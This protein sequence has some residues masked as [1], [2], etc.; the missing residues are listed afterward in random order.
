VRAHERGHDR[1]R[2]LQL[3][4][5]EMLVPNRHEAA[6]WYKRVLGLE[7]VPEYEFWAQDP[8]GP[9]MVSSDCG[10][11]KLALFRG[12]TDSA[13]GGPGFRLV[14]FR[15]DGGGFI[16]FVRRLESLQLRDHRGHAVTIDSVVDHDKAYSVYFSDPYGHRLEVT[17]YD[18]DALR[19]ALTELRE[20]A[21]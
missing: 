8:H 16:A 1:F 2:V 13:E 10:S 5:V 3:D 12:P 21:R 17:S 9:L 15:V 19:K 7:I 20:Q 11:T 18:H 6:E 4:H 14:A